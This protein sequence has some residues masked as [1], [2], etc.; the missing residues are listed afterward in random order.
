MQVSKCAIGP[1]FYID[2]RCIAHSIPD[3]QGEK[4]AGKLDNP[5][6][7]EALYDDH[8]DS[9][10]YIDVP[11]GRVVWDTETDRAILYLDR[12]IEKTDGA[13]EKTAML[14]DLTD[15]VVEHDEHYVCP[16]CM[17]DIWRAD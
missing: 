16:N 8:F 13:I 6:S 1:F 3:W 2:G 14:F 17:G 5:Y 9:G 11:R 12:C 4:R 7:H 10:D 15:Y